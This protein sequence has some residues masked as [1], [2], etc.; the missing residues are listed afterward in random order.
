MDLNGWYVSIILIINLIIFDVTLPSYLLLLTCWGVTLDLPCSINTIFMHVAHSRSAELLS[1]VITSKYATAF[2]K[3]SFLVVKS[4]A[5]CNLRS[6][7]WG[8]SL[9]N[10]WCCLDIRQASLKRE[11][12]E[13]VLAHVTTECIFIYRLALDRVLWRYSPPFKLRIVYWNLYNGRILADVWVLVV[14]WEVILPVQWLYIL[15]LF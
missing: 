13:T 5:L 2:L 7:I 12:V 10:T 11:V 4:P 15:V 3:A 9:H 1:S 6:L 14:F 8:I